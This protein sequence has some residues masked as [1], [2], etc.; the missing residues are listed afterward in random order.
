M[1]PI[2]VLIIQIISLYNYVLFAWVILSMLV[3]FNIVNPYQPF[4]RKVMEVLDRLVEPL[5]RPIRKYI[6]HLG[7]LDLSPMVLILA[8][9]FI[10]NTLIYY[11]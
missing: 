8:L 5:L 2:I 9:Q 11:S 6:P 3:Y 10:T 4:V 1:N 7:G